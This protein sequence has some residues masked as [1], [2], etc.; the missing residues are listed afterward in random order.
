[1]GFVGI[2]TDVGVVAQG[3]DLDLMLDDQVAFSLRIQRH[4]RWCGVVAASGSVNI[5]L[6]ESEII[7]TVQSTLKRM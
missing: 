6:D 1:M 2:N 5:V 3:R 4:L 7:V